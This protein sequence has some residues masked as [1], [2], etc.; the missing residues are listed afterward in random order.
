MEKPTIWRGNYRSIILAFAII[1]IFLQQIL[2]YFT[3]AQVHAGNNYL[4]KHVIN[5]RITPDSDD[6]LSF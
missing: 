2:Y 3:Q 1:N 4:I 6:E 5:P